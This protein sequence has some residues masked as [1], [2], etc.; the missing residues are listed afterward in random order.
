MKKFWIAFIV[1]AVVVG[2]GLGFLWYSFSQLEE[3][4]S[5]DGGLLVWEVGGTFPEE[6]DDSFWGQVRAGSEL[7]L[8][9]TAFAL[10]RAAEDERI[11]G[12][13][14][15]LRGL[16]TDWAKLEELRV[17]VAAFK[18]SGKP[19][20]AY[21]DG[22]STRDY[23]LAAQA[24]EIV[25]SPEASIMVLGVVAELSFMK[26]TLD[27]LG[28]KADFIHVGKYKS[29]PER[30]TRN[31]ASDSNREM[32][33][34]IVQDRYDDLVDG[35]AT[36]RGVAPDRVE[37]WVDRGMFDAEAA[38]KEG[39]ADTVMYFEQL[40]EARFPEEES[41][42]LSDYVLASRGKSSSSH[43]VGVVY[44]TGVIMPGQSRFDNFQGKIAGSETVVEH[45]QSVGE[46]QSVDIVIL[47]IDS[48]GGSALAS[49][50]IWDA[51]GEVQKEKPVIVSMSGMAASGGYYIA[52]RADSIFADPGT[53]TGSIGVYA[54]KMDRSAMYRKIG[55]NR[56]FITRGENA[57]LFSD[58][59][60]FTGEQR[61]LFEEQMGNFYERFLAKVAEG[62]GMT[63]A[64]AHAVAQGRVWTGNQGLEHGLVDQ[65]G[66]LRRAITSA[67]WMLGLQESDKIAIASFGEELS[68]LERMLLKSLREG[69]GF[70]KLVQN[71]VPGG[72]AGQMTGLGVDPTGSLPVPLLLDSLREDGTLAAISLLDGRPVAMMPFW[73]KVR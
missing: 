59:G 49:D 53:L 19:V 71:I 25:M 28:M 8:G 23:A 26:D 39:L 18:E 11:T 31:E 27:K 69:G 48:P 21:L 55:V 64:Q 58:E 60:G 15:D 70:A 52:C 42:Y 9:E 38:L 34:A 5:I 44:A 10:Y 46:D 24:D 16:Q 67:K 12:L 32:I 65:I 6:R 61:A 66:G 37:G 20:V 56:E 43:K 35:L 29:A 33:E 51:I 22:A 68:L 36:D 45:L 73:I 7:T 50:L 3:S 13:L 47:R 62:R 14:M 17:A 63:R 4:V 1:L 40:L 41:T 57:L 72:L 2:G 30:M 54:G